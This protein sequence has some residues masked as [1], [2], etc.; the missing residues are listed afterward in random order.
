MS[1]IQNRKKQTELSKEEK[2]RRAREFVNAYAR[3]S[4]LAFQ[5]LVL[6]GGGAYLGIYLD[7]KNQT[8]PVW[9]VIFSLLGVALSFYTL[10]KSLYL[11]E[12]HSKQMNKNREKDDKK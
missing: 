3:Y 2:A 12:K 5:M 11:M 6:I 10:Y 4:G 1:R 9:T 7:E 8:K